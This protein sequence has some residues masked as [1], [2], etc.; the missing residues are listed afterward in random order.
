VTQLPVLPV[1]VPLAAAVLQLAVHR[2]GVEA[3]RAIGLSSAMLVLLLAAALLWVTRDGAVPALALGNWPAPF[4]IVFMADRLAATMVAVTALVALPALLA[5]MDGT[6]RLGR[7]FHPLFQIQ[8][9][10]LNGA[11]LTGDLFNLFVFF[12]VLLI[13]SYA[14]L[15]HG[16]GE[17]RSRAGLHYVVLNLA[18]SLLFLI[19]LGLLY[20]TLGTLNIADLAGRVAA[21]PEDLVP[22]ARAAFALLLAVFAF[23]A[24]LLPLGFW[25]P[26]AYGAATAPVAA[27]F[28]VLTK[29]GIYAMLRLS[30]AVFP[31]AEWA[32]GL[33]APWLMPVALATVVAATIGTLAARRLGVM[34]A[35][36]LLLSTGMLAAAVAEG[37]PRMLAAML[38]YLP[39]TTLVSA[40]LFLL[41]GRIAAAR[42][43]AADRVEH[44]PRPDRF[45]PLGAAWLVLAIA[46]TGLPPLSGF[47]GKVMLLSAAPA[48]ATGTAMWIVL[49]L[50]GFAGALAMARAGSVVFWE[51]PKDRPDLALAAPSRAPGLG[52]ALLLALAFVPLLVLGAAPLS[53]HAR[54]VAEQISTRQVY[55]AAALPSP[56]A[57]TREARP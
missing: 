34:A 10:G 24:A 45:L 41:V 9:A 14:L 53:M 21:L 47:L 38:Y 46:V 57:A 32:A 5:A 56:D 28:A 37:G 11:F 25:L 30:T 22:P 4:G 42:G 26:H 36:L 12:E 44:A 13:A 39:H 35:H 40:A 52:A 7:H 8:L 16:G 15:A 31:A 27:I 43:A 18:G 17:A 48:S 51:R 29:V 6:D 1:L 19:G 33:L 55:D 54:A 3:A 49:I 2:A 23:K 20:G 50:S